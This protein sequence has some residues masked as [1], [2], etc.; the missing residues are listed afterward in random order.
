M[1]GRRVLLYH[2]ITDRRGFLLQ[3]DALSCF[4]SVPASEILK[5]GAPCIA[6]TF[7]DGWT[8]LLWAFPE[9]RKRG[10]SATLFLTTALPELRA[11]GSWE[12]FIRERFPRLAQKAALAPLAWDELRD[13]VSEGLEIG[14]H[15]HTHARLGPGAGEELRASR[16]LIRENLGVDTR[17]FAYPYGRRRDID[18]SARGLLGSCGYD[19]A[20]IGHGWAIPDNCDPLL[21]PRHPVKESWPLARLLDT[22]S[23][24][25]DLREKLSWWAQGLIWVRAPRRGYNPSIL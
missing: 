21:V 3:A 4:P 10:L 6:I 22:L 2:S 13:L 12:G 1:K 5:A 17:I 8:D 7:D 9:L 15:T 23:G 18:L 19:M 25:A 24:K 20:F 11:S 14:S 16:E